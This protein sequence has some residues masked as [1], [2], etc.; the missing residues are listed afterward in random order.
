MYQ[1]IGSDGRQYGPIE[2]EQLKQWARQGRVDPRTRVLAGTPPAWQLAGELPELQGLFPGVPPV[3][4][5]SAVDIPTARPQGAGNSG[6]ATASFVMGLLGLLCLG[7]FAGVPAVICGHVA[8]S[9]EKRDPKVYRAGGL[10]KAGLVL[11]YVSIAM[12]VIFGALL[13]PIVMKSRDASHRA[14]CTQ[15]LHQI[16]N[17]LTVWASD[18]DS[19]FPFN[20]GTN[21]G[22]TMDYSQARADGFDQAAFK[23]FQVLGGQLSSPAILVCPANKKT[24]PA[25]NFEKLGPENITYQLRSGEQVAPANP[26]E[27]LVYCPTHRIG[28]RCDGSLS[29]KRGLRKVNR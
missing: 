27:L 11:G 19:Q 24:S 16:Q 1:I 25:N 26:G 21:E 20:V 12:S 7:I 2:L 28:I 4:T 3:L 5:P 6:L 13:I 10:A 8:R 14:Q 9:R 22:G 29:T 15:Q 17:A 18:H 23:H